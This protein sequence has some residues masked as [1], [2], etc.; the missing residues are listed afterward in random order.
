MQGIKCYTKLKLV[1]KLS[2]KP[3]VQIDNRKYFLSGEINFG[4]GHLTVKYETY[5]VH[6]QKRLNKLSIR[7]F[8]A[9][10]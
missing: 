3:H 7:P 2:L 5:S 4:L 1:H 9:E 6:A 8:P 10:I